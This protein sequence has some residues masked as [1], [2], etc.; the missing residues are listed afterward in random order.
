MD[1]LLIGTPPSKIIAIIVSVTIINV[2]K[3]INLLLYFKNIL[4]L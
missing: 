1:G 2:K 3:N 4:N